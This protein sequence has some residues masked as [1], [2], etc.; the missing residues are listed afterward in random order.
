M[1]WTHRPGFATAVLLAAMV[2]GVS[3][4]AWA[5]EVSGTATPPT[6]ELQDD[7]GAEAPAA[8]DWPVSFAFDAAWAGK[9]VWR[10]IVVTEDPVFQPS[11]EVAVGDLTLNVWANIDTT[12]VNDFRRQANE[13]DYTLDYTVFSWE[14]LTASVGAIH[15]AFPQAHVFD[16]TEAYLSLAA[17][18]PTA[19]T[20]TVYQDLDEHDGQYITLGFGHTFK[21]VWT[22]SPEVAMSVDLSA[23]FAWGSRKHNAFYYGSG[24][25]WADTT[26]GL[27]L[28]FAVGENVTVT[29]CVNY[30][31]I[32]DDGVSGALG[33]D[34]AFWAGLSVTVG[35]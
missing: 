14:G 1:D 6:L 32:L 17:D 30:M 13:I 15:Y 19:P 5:E 9:Y 31:W 29:P 16:T 24:S 26:V 25:G 34:D 27:A 8:E 33:R 35:F 21:D 2:A 11:V 3:A 22:P 7:P 12:D 28:P 10:G 18:V 20:L 23:Q 4:P